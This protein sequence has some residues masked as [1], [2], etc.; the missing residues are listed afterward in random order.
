MSEKPSVLRTT[1]EPALHL[2]RVLV[3]SAPFGALATFDVDSGFPFSSR[4]LLGTDF[5]GVP[6]I[7]VSDLSTHTRGLRADRR[8][9]I[10]AG[11]PQKGD[12]LNSP[13][14]TVLSEAE[15]VDRPSP[16]HMRIR[17]RFLR[18]HPKAKLYVD[19]GDFS[20]FRLTPLSASLNGGFGKAYAIEGRELLIDSP[21]NVELSENDDKLIKIL[22]NLE[23]KSVKKLARICFSEKTGRWTL[24]NIDSA[25]FELSFGSEIRRF[26]FNKII[27]SQEELL[28][29]YLTLLK[30]PMNGSQHFSDL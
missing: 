17:R 25:G 22:S 12:P 18:R 4:V 2:A 19:F 24:S 29:I 20:F 5:D 23:N 26:E 16:D 15:R 13:R 27:S 14:I 6:V 10:L 8:C 3:R 11:E 1:D 28:N 9:S 30:E 7:L 21:V